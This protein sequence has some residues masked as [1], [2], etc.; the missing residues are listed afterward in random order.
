MKI[1][2]QGLRETTL[3]AHMRGNRDRMCKHCER[4][5]KRH[6][7]M[8]RRHMTDVESQVHTESKRQPLREPAWPQQSEEPIAVARPQGP[9]NTAAFAQR[10]PAQ[11][12][13]TLIFPTAPR[14][15]VA[16][17]SPVAVL[18]QPVPRVS[19]VRRPVAVSSSFQR[20]QPQL[21]KQ[22]LRGPLQ[23]AP[24]TAHTAADPDW[25]HHQYHARQHQGV[26]DPVR[27]PA[28]ISRVVDQVLPLQ[29]QRPHSQ[30][31]SQPRQQQKQHPLAQS[32]SQPRQQQ[33]T[34]MI[35]RGADGPSFHLHQQQQA[36]TTPA[37]YRPALPWR[38]QPRQQPL[39]APVPRVAPQI[40]AR[41]INTVTHPAG[42][43][44][45]VTCPHCGGG[46]QVARNQI[47]CSIFR[48]GVYNE[49]AFGSVLTP[50]SSEAYGPCLQGQL[51]PP[52]AP[53]AL[54]DRVIKEDLV[55]GCG[56]PFRFDGTS[57]T[58][59]GYL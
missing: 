11:P 13:R 32:I 47:A 7:Q 54:C 3:L 57:T 44:Y 18:Q 48:H 17:Q 23:P 46:I 22:T 29:Q 50:S 6:D 5:K 9:V 39:P 45:F 49:R 8:K 58:K 41:T 27:H 59:C 35:R 16:G 56:K 36:M 31:V 4:R 38:I 15:L 2:H 30:T 51:L 25:T 14:L 40:P 55:Y 37:A 1:H 12:S 26:A 21:S 24:M 52:H 20:Q 28:V 10:P 53:Q 19:A 33:Q 34:V 43:D 42:Q